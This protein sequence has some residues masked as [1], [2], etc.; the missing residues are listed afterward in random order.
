MLQEKSQTYKYLWIFFVIVILLIIFAVIFRIIKEIQESAFTNNSFSVL[1]VSKDSKLIYVDK[2]QGKVLFLA[3]GDVER[4]VKGKN[5]LEAT[6]SLGIPING[7]IYDENPPVNIDHFVSTKNE[8]RL[9]F[10][11]KVEYK[12][13]NKLDVV[14]LIGALKDSNKDNKKEVRVNIFEE[15]A[16]KD[17]E[18]DFVDSVI[19]NSGLTIEI[20]NGTSINGLGN[21]LALI[22]SKQGYNVV[23]VRTAQPN[24]TSFIAFNE[25]ESVTTN[26][27]LDLTGFSFRKE[28]VSKAADITIY[29]G[30]DV[31]AMLSI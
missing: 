21:L 20:D 10:D 13:M 7:I 2:A 29:L 9:L 31:D 25:E 22:L 4:F 23:A 17:L 14:K 26:S 24:I 1:I 15:K 27:L 18:E 6:F 28:K 30:E 16:I 8:I 12:N 5:T 19:R 3:L 11:G